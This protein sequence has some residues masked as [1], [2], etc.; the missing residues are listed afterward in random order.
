MRSRH[1]S[2]LVLAIA[3]GATTQAMS[4]GRSF[5]VSNTK[6]SVDPT[7]PASPVKIE[8]REGSAVL[9][10]LAPAVIHVADNGAV[11]RAVDTAAHLQ[12]VPLDAVN[13]VAKASVE[14]PQKAAAAAED[15]V[16]S[17]F[18]KM[19]AQLIQAYND[20][21]SRLKSATPWVVAGVCGALFLV[22]FLGSLSAGVA[23][24]LFG[25]PRSRA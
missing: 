24:R 4:A 3:L 17:P 16:T 21:V 20:L 13:D 15:A 8:R 5:Q 19:L 14:L 12:Q 18:K 7:K 11:A 23:L 25:S 10:P 6:I 1:P 2:Y 9:S 22:V